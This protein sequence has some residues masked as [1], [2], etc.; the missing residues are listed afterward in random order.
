[1]HCIQFFGENCHSLIPE[2]DIQTYVD[3][4]NLPRKSLMS[5]KGKPASFAMALREIE[6]AFEGKEHCIAKKT[7]WM[8]LSSS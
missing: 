4:Q 6:E 2:E 7:P 5:T 3:D 1:M 8:K